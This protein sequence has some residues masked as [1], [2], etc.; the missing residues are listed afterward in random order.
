MDPVRLI[1]VGAGGRGSGYATYARHHP[2][3]LQIAGVAEP[4]DF[5]R[6]RLAD[7][8]DI[9]Y[10][11]IAVDWRE[12]AARPRFADGVIITTQDAMHAE[13]AV[14]FANLGYHVLLEKPMAP[15]ADDCRRIV[16]AAKRNDI[17]FAV[18]HVMRYTSYT[19]Q[20][21]AI[22][23][24]G[25]IGEIVSIEHLEPVGYWHQAHS[26]VRGNWRNE[27]ESS[28]MLLAKSC[29]DLDWLRYLMG[30]PCVQVSSFG[31]LKHFRPEEAP[32]G[33]GERCLECPVEPVCPYSAV[34]IYL[35]RVRRGET[36][37]PVNVLTPD[38]TEEG[39]TEALR[40]GP[41]G[42]C[43]YG[44]DNDVVDHQVVNLLFANGAT[45][46]FTMTAFTR[47]RDRETHIFGTRGEIYGNGSTIQIY[48]FLTDQTETVQTD[49]AS[50]GSILTGHGGGDY[51]I[52]QRFVTALATGDRSQIL[53]GPDET[54]ETH[55]MVFA[56][57]AA[58]REGRVAAV[59]L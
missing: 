24:S 7:D 56:A 29:H 33:A 28:P 36:G 43:V 39:V 27:A 32:E 13:P 50:D 11:N 18:C 4:R 14:A 53:S 47:Q 54:L 52:M 38:V 9:P 51:G 2:E 10:D 25:R 55:L 45:A 42:R 34:K 17:I 1:V 16:D 21:K 19:Q 58:R 22:L 15:N 37:W 20:L 5:Y 57:E 8:Y 48:D 6:E 26:F 59:T 49:R 44:C 40:T 12:L 31:S 35:G 3:Q 46:S 30:Q 23:D 41:Y